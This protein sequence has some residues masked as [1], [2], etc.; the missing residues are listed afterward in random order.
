[1]NEGMNERKKE[2]KKERER[3]LFPYSRAEGVRERERGP[4]G[5]CWEDG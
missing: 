5:V 2:R 4:K 3:I 1:M